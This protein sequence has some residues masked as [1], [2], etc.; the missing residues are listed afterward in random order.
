MA[1]QCTLKNW[2]YLEPQYQYFPDRTDLGGYSEAMDYVPI[3]QGYMNC[4]DEDTAFTDPAITQIRTYGGQQFCN[5]CRC[6]ASTLKSVSQQLLKAGVPQYGLCY[7]ANCAH[8]QYLQLYVNHYWY[9]C[10]PDGGKI[11]IPGMTGYV[12]CPAAR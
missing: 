7:K 12:V 2:N 8:S 9:S 1:G 6:F 11:F 3:Y 10:P 4:K 5:N